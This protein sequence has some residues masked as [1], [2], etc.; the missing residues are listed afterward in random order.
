MSNL[1]DI[2]AVKVVG[3]CKAGKT[4]LAAGLQSLGFEARASA[5]EH[6]GVPDAWQR[7]TPARWLVY[8]DVNVEA[9]C[10]RSGRT[11]WTE[12]ILAE[13]RR[14]LRHARQH[15][16]IYLDTTELTAQQVL[17]Q[18]AEALQRLAAAGPAAP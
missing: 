7:F 10:R 11:D 4:T 12:E 15:A 2:G 13:Q 6:S 18:V 16:E 8:L 14:R 3:P 17:D 5:Q 1:S 9:M